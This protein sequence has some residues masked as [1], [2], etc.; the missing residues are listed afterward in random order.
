MH[1]WRYT[2]EGKHRQAVRLLRSALRRNPFDYNAMVALAESLWEIGGHGDEALDLARAA[3][4]LESRSVDALRTLGKILAEQRLFAEALGPLETVASE[5]DD[6]VTLLYLGGSLRGLGRKDEALAAFRRAVA[7]S[8]QD[9]HAHEWLGNMLDELGRHGEAIEPLSM[10]IKLGS[11]SGDLRNT[12]GACL[13]ELGR[14]EEAIPVLEEAVRLLEENENPLMNLGLVM[15][16]LSRWSEALDCFGKAQK[17]RPDN[18]SGFGCAGEALVA[19]GRWEKAREA[20][21]SALGLDPD[22]FDH[23]PD[24]KAAW[25]R[26]SSQVNEGRANSELRN[27]GHV[28]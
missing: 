19:L 16:K 20:F 2:F 12:L 3:V 26:L 4:H 10:A 22:Y 1:G 6:S 7:A 14:Y 25:N 5:S 13:G 18:P 21:D 11:R 15:G 24:K 9:S 17:L 23:D 27:R 8:P 28:N